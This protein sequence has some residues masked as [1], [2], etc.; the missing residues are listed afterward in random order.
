MHRAGKVTDI[1]NHN[2]ETMTRD[3]QWVIRVRA[4]GMH[5]IK[6]HFFTQKWK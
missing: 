2:D 3:Q 4:I 1:I 6:S 5:D